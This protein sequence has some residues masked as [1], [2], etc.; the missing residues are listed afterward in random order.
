MYCLMSDGGKMFAG[1]RGWLWYMTVNLHTSKINCM[2]V[3]LQ[4]MALKKS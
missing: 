2:S 1:S 3:A 4:Y